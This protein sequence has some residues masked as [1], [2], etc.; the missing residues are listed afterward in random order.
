MLIEWS[1]I[2]SKSDATVFDTLKEAENV[3][4]YLSLTGLYVTE[5]K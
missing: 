4:E 2:T 1:L 5:D 3:V